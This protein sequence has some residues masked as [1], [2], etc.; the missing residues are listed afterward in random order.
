MII[1]NQAGI[2]LIESFEGCP[3]TAYQDTRGIWTIGRGHTGPEVVPGLIWTQVQADQ[4]FL[5]DLHQRAEGPLN[6]LLRVTLNPNQFAALCSLAFNI[7]A[8]GFRASS[9]LHLCNLGQL[10]QVP[11][12]ILLWDRNHDGSIN[13]GLV[14]R[15]QAECALW[16]KTE[17]TAFMRD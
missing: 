6:Q 2:E 4:Q 17:I 10:D 9:A 11:A 12:H 15:R 8:G 13:A 14:R 16:A 5:Q 3:L 1:C 7:G